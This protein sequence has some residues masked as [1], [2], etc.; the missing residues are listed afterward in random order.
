MAED[1][2]P[3]NIP[4][5]CI[6]W[7]CHCKPSLRLVACPDLG[8]KQPPIPLNFFVKNLHYALCRNFS[9]YF[10]LVLH[11]V[12]FVLHLLT[13]PVLLLHLQCKLDPF[14]FAQA[15]CLNRNS[16]WS[17][18]TIYCWFSGLC[19]FSGNLSRIIWCFLAICIIWYFLAICII[20]CFLAI[21]Y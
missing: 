17:T 6:F 9:L 10:L 3:L 19:C 4:L 14:F 15:V 2:L 21:C 18:W 8:M 5:N 20:W 11:E 7:K 12:Y 1:K 16:R 13:D